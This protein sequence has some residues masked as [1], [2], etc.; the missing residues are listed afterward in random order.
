M[1]RQLLLTKIFWHLQANW[2]FR[3]HP[4]PHAL[5]IQETV[6]GLQ[7]LLLAEQGAM[8]QQTLRLVYARPV[9]LEV[10]GRLEIA[11]YQEGID[12]RVWRAQ[13]MLLD[14]TTR[15]FG[16]I[17]ARAPGASSLV[18][19]RDCA[20]LRTLHRQQGRYCVAP[21]VYGTAPVAGGVAAYTVEWL[22][23]HKELVVEIT[24]DGG[25]FL[26]NAHGA[27][28]RFSPQESRQIW[29]RIVEILWWY[30]TVRAVNIQAGDFVVRQHAKGPI[31]LKLTTARELALDPTPA[32]QMHA[33]LG[34]MI[35][36]SGYLSDGQQPFDRHMQRETFMHRMQA[37]L[38]RRFGDQ[39]PEL[40]QRQWLLFQA[41]A[42]A[43]QEDGLKEDCVLA[44]Y[45]RLRADYPAA[46]AWQET[47]QRWLSYAEA[48]HSGRLPASW[49]FPAAEIPRVLDR[50]ARQWAARRPL[51]AT[52]W[53]EGAQ[54]NGRPSHRA[55][56]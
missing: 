17:M 24:L 31:E 51:P 26:V 30:P 44:T 11:L 20:N 25:V 48:V 35:T 42:F 53:A 55:R 37:V 36:A 5:S 40:A 34:C 13:A 7:G 41:G 19:Q 8:L 56:L 52:A 39:A 38:R 14:G 47:C 18:T 29:R 2:H 33:I 27:H 32:E 12:Q 9:S 49:W 3:H 1:D 22:D 4:V 45:D 15:H 28:R 16:I 43:Q 21:Y 46:V 6:K 50:L 10:L 54:L 23:E